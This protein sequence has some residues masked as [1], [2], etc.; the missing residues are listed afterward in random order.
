[1][2]ALAQTEIQLEKKW[3]P[4]CAAFQLATN[5]TCEKCGSPMSYLK[6]QAAEATPRLILKVF[7]VICCICGALLIFAA[8]MVSDKNHAEEAVA[9][10]AASPAAEST[11]ATKPAA[12]QKWH[13]AWTHYM[14][15]QSTSITKFHG[16][17]DES[18]LVLYENLTIKNDGPAAVKDIAIKCDDFAPSGTAIDSNE[19]TIYE[20]VPAHKTRTFYRFNMGFINPQSSASSCVIENLTVGG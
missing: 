13:P 8:A 1:M 17:K 5:P 9:T 19:R 3:C 4:K 12:E 6:M 14:A 20:I 11:P 16:Y 2:R 18:G 10:A 7:F 15:M